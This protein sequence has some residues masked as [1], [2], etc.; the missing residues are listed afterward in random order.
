MA[1]RL[2]VFQGQTQKSRRKLQAQGLYRQLGAN[3]GIILFYG[4]AVMRLGWGVRLP[5]LWWPG[6]HGFLSWIE[7][8][9]QRPGLW[10]T[11]INHA[12]PAPGSLY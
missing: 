6:L 12:I 5:N 4:G 11:D 1:V 3:P 7:R 9:F 10:L 8:G 2:A